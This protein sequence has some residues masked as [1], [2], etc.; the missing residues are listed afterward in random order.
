MAHSAESPNSRWIAA[1]IQSGARTAA[2]AFRERGHTAEISDLYGEGFDAREA[3]IQ[4]GTMTAIR[5]QALREVGGWDE[6]CICEDTELGLRQTLTDQIREC[7]VEFSK[8]I[9]RN[10]LYMEPCSYPQ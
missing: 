10:Y 7:N 8:F 4:H 3:L 9:E 1:A 5:A 6:A 2:E